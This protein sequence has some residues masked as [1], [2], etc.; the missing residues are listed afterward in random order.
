MVA[1][2]SLQ[3]RLG[4]ND[5]LCQPDFQNA[6]FFDDDLSR[7]CAKLYSFIVFSFF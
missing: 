5:D 6:V 7:G 3:Q 4:G 2:G 1:L